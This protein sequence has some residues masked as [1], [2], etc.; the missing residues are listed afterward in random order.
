M[1]CQGNPFFGG[2][3]HPHP[4]YCPTHAILYNVS[5]CACLYKTALQLY[6]VIPVILVMRDETGI[7][8]YT[9][10]KEV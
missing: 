7:T 6:M 5:V 4:N 1:D 8:F 2:N 3:E 10:L 9:G